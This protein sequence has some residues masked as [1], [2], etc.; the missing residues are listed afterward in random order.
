MFDK[1]S[2]RRSFVRG[3]LLTATA[4][5]LPVA[6]AAAKGTTPPKH[7]VLLGDSIF[8]NGAYVGDGPDVIEQLNRRL[9]A[10]ARATLNAM[11]GSV[12]SAV[13]L[14]LQIAPDDATHFVISAGG[15]DALHQAGLLEEKAS[16]VAEA[17][18]KLAVVRDKFEQD[19]RA[20]LD[21]VTARGHP[22]A[23]CTIYDPRFDDAKQRRIAAIS[24]GVFNDTITREA[25]ARG[26]ALIDLRLICTEDEDLANPIE[27]SVIGGAKI[28]GAI[29]A[30]AAD[31]DFSQGRCEVF[32]GADAK[33]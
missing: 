8:A 11:D 31:Y 21:E 12:A 25:A 14:Q 24:L 4:L 30:F 10:G 7:I 22:V 26:L 13:R 19:Y 1:P 15:N 33:T 18:A 17:L 16:S 6:R 3:A 2:S 5:S 9:P 23:V 27:P 29:A 20:M 28:A 32:T